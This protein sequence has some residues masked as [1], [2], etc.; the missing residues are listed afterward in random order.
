MFSYCSYSL[1]DLL[2][3][4]LLVTTSKAQCYITFSHLQTVRED[5][6]VIMQQGIQLVQT[7]GL[8]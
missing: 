6:G 7:L 3:L 4:L 2:I 1:P 5:Q 8:R